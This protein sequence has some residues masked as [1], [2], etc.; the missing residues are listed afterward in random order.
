MRWTALEA[1]LY[2]RFTTAADVWS[3]G[4]VMWETLSFG[5]R[6]FWQWAN[7]D[8]V[9]AVDAGYRLPPPYVFIS[10]TV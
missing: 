5:E 7:Q 2:R 4:V 10:F 1:I 3:F 9:K 8:V 6:P